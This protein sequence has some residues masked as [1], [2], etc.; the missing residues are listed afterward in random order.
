MVHFPLLTLGSAV[1][2]VEGIENSLLSVF[3]KNYPLE[4]KF[5]F[6]MNYFICYFA[7]DSNFLD[8]VSKKKIRFGVEKSEKKEIGENSR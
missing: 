4:W 6:F 3:P 1:H 5:R 8:Q 7:F 2:K